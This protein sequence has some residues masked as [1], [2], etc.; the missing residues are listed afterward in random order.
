MDML[1]AIGILL[2]G[3]VLLIKGADFF[4][5][6]S[7]AVAKKLRIPSIIVGLTIVA[8]GTSLPELAVSV[9]A[10]LAGNNEI[11]VSNVVGSNLFNL[12]V[13][14]GV[15]TLFAP[16]T[17]SKS[18]LKSD[19]PLSIVCAVL[20][21][22][23]GVIG[24][25][26]GRVDGIILSVIFVTY[27]A[28]LVRQALKARANSAANK[29]EEK[30]SG[31][32]IPVWLCIIYIIGG[33]VAIKFGGD[34]VVDGASTI[35]Q[36]LGMSQTLVGLTVVAVGTSLPELVTSIVAGRKGEVDMALGNV[37]GSNIFNILFILGVAGSI[38]PM[39]FIQD[40]IID[41]AVLIAVSLLTYV[42][43]W[44][45]QRL[46]KKEGIIMI[47]IYAAYMVYAC[48]RGMGLLA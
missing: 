14:C 9:T 26:V 22:V 3:F 13:V 32:D 15:C 33:I 6:G 40:N 7:S 44:S 37:I 16:L 20:L 30:E 24:M 12:L 19:F 45:K 46:D 36:K 42:F 48:F 11:A 41:L 47:L 27:I 17:I 21:L 34:F 8:M 25:Q 18:T 4:V 35:A 29:E 23:M 38:S 1:K 2:V 43:A 31:K 5:E 28:I 39:S 10:S